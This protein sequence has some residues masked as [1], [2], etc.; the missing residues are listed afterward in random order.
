MASFDPFE[1]EFRSRAQGLRRTPSNQGWNRIEQR[2]D[3]RRR[4]GVSIFGLRPWM[5][6][7]LVLIVAGVSI[8]SNIGEDR[9]NPLAKRAAFMEELSSPYIPEQTFEPKE[10]FN[11][12]PA[13]VLET[14]AMDPDPD[15]RDVQVARKY[16]V[17]G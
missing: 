8:I 10:Y 7:A 2:L 17:R 5:I 15:F 14:D 12:I 9:N 1:K 16:Q 3:R 11:G 13:E 4:G 6:A